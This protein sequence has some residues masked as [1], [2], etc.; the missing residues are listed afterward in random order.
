MKRVLIAVL[1]TFVAV[2][3][4][5]QNRKTVAGPFR[6]GLARSHHTNF[7]GYFSFGYDF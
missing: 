1:A 2:S 5:A 3:V 7:G 4:F 6:I